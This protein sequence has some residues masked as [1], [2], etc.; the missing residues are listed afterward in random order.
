MVD[1]DIFELNEEEQEDGQYLSGLPVD[2]SFP[3][4]DETEEVSGRLAGLEPDY[5]RYGTASEGPSVVGLALRAVLI[6]F[7]AALLGLRIWGWVPVLTGSAESDGGVDP[8]A[9]SA[10]FAPDSQPMIQARDC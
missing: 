2:V 5:S 3:I 7:W 1:V 6:V 10:E 9:P 8:C 4:P